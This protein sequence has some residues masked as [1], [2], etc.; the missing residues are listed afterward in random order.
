MNVPNERVLESLIEASLLSSGYV[1]SEP[2]N[3]NRELGID[4][5]DLFA[6][7]GATQVR[8]WD[9]Y[10][11]RGHGGDV[12]KAQ[13]GFARRLANELSVRGT[14]DVLRHGV[15]DVG[16]N[17]K[18]AYFKPA[19]GL[20]PEL[21]EKYEANRVGV[22]R[23][24]NYEVGSEKDIDIC[25]LVNG[26]P[27]ATAEL[28]NPLTGQKVEHA[29]KQYRE[30]RDAKNV[31]LAHRAV[32]HF[33]LDVESVAMTTKLDGAKTRFL[34]FNQGSGGA[35]QQGGAGNPVNPNGHKTAYLWEEVWARDAWMDLL[36][37][38]IHVE[39]SDTRAWKDAIA[40]RSVIFPRFHQWDAVR[41]LEASAKALGAGQSYLVQHSAGS[42]KSNTIGWIAHRLSNLHSVT[43]G[44]VFDKVV[45][46]TDRVLL[47]K[48]LQDT[49][50]QFEH[51]HGVVVRIDENSAQLAAALSGEQAKIIITTLQKFPYILKEI[52][53][54]P[55]RKYAVIID[56]AHSSQ[57]GQA[58]KDL[59]AALSKAADPT[60]EELAAAEQDD[61][62]D[63]SGRDDG[64]DLLNKAV[65]GRG[66][67]AN[68]SF[69]AFTATPKAKTLEIFGQKVEIGGQS[70]FVPFHLYSMKQA[71]EEG[72][73]IDVLKNYTTYDTYWKVEKETP[74]DPEVDKSKA[75]AAIARFVS[76]HPHNLSQKAEIIVEH[77]RQHTRSKIGGKAK[78][79]VV[80]SSRLHAVRYKQSIDSYIKDKGYTD[81]QALVAYSGKVLDA[82]AEFSEAKMNG[83]PEKETAKRFDSD[84]YQVL[85]VAEKFQ[86]GFDQ[87]LL[88]TMY[89]DKPLS[90]LHAVQTLS[91]LNRIHPD[92]TDTFV[93]DFRNTTDDI[94]K[95]FKPWF[96]KTAAI[97]TDPN[98]LWDTHRSLMAFPVIIVS[99]IKPLVS[100]V[101]TKGL[102]GE[103]A[104]RAHEQIYAML[105]P[106]VARFGALS[107]KDQ[108]A[109]RDT[110][111]RFLSL[112]SF[113][114][115]I[116]NFVDTAMERDFIYCRMLEALLPTDGSTRI[117]L[118]SDVTLT[119]L[120]H[121]KMFEGSAALD[122]GEGDV[123]AIFDGKGKAHDPEEERLSEIIRILNEQFGLQLTDTDKLLFDQFEEV[124][125]SNSD[126]LAQARNNDF[127]NFLLV[128]QRLFLDTVI[129]RMDVNDEIFQ[130][131]L[132]DANFKELLL[133]WYAR[134]VFSKANKPG[135]GKS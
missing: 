118:G 101:L 17:F 44:K 98:L 42:G 100:A 97:P 128:F 81:I 91:R 4:T 132:N 78:A 94:Q 53:E 122:V 2:S 114:S 36:A 7:I 52:G 77:F 23:Q 109:F 116:L 34:P 14:V 25:L 87:P 39:K 125:L 79:M 46:I 3:F 26:I 15:S 45:V 62:A 111:G 103:A 64:E 28:K 22:M 130:R 27:T 131:I 55:R 75:K 112:Y 49:I 48:Q 11:A 54:M 33:A 41:K 99:E 63:E 40:S 76:L 61:L 1:K 37:R 106:P 72:F 117:D 84:D 113:I 93:L 134:Q 92:K 123:K 58:A 127:D 124:W 29:I 90:G 35:G 110:I 8:E 83:F 5:A 119:H 115:Q 20:T 68:I 133:E 38:F 108:D 21:L 31:S 107:E 73:I 18:L 69:F 43:D 121:Q 95:S 102:R 71:I 60:P 47:D 129:N 24:F 66:K 10:V 86:T 135:K 104:M 70:R 9:S 32:V 120:R 80:T 89:V 12:T 57:T 16:I 82:G 19:H 51:A 74:D 6:F 65:A 105:N 59:R 96:E 67:Q 30:D 85:I 88:H 56:E 50:Y 126:I 13:Q